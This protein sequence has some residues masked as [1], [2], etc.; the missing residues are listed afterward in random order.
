MKTNLGFVT[1][2]NDF[3]SNAYTVDNLSD[4]FKNKKKIKNFTVIVNV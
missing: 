3:I 1:N 2:K 4:R